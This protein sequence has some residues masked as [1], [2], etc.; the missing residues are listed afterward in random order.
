MIQQNIKVAADSLV[1]STA[2][3][4]LHL[5]LIKRR[6][7]PYKGQWALPGGFVEND[8]DLEAAAIRELKEETGME[9]HEMGQLAA[10]GTPGRDPRGR[11]VSVVY[12]AITKT[13]DHVAGSDDAAEAKWVNVK[14][15]STLAFDHKDI[16]EYA[17][18]VLAEELE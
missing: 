1:L 4:E 3:G 13:M 12:Y 5:L 15:I 7:D 17:L 14:E 11:C 2:H 10:F 6:N 8:E 9:L 18:W 16:L